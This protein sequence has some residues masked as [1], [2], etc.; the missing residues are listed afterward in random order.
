MKNKKLYALAGVAALAAV[1]GTFA[2]YSAVQTFSNPFD[3]SNYGTYS[4][5]KFNPGDGHEWIPGAEVDKEVFATNT[6]DG[7]VWVRVKLDETWNKVAGE[8]IAIDSTGIF[9][10]ENADTSRQLSGTDGKTD[11]DG[12]VVYKHIVN[13]VEEANNTMEKK[14][15]YQNG[16]YYYTSA[17]EKD[18]STA[19][20]LDSVTLCADTDMGKFNDVQAYIIVNKGSETPV[21][22]TGDWTDGPLPF[23]PTDETQLK[24]YEGKDIYTYKASEL[25][26]KDHGYAN[27]DYALNITVEFLQSTE[28][29]TEA[30]KIIEAANTGKLEA[31]K[32][33]WYPGM[34]KKTS[35]PAETSAADGE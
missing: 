10:P 30:A 20:L 15:F 2:Y 18:E 31:E 7:E 21:Y 14:W 25:D 27:A 16:Y 8:N 28:V 9:L 24:A 4:Y 1:G 19:K 26:A 22:P 3:T 35:A 6:G 12:S 33:T 34:P 13:T 29:E 17:L 5:E 11:G 23:D 32:W